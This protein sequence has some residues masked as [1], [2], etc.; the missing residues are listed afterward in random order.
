MYRAMRKADLFRRHGMIASQADAR[1]REAM[2][3]KVKNVQP[4]GLI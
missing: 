3:N 4:D 2:V 1:A